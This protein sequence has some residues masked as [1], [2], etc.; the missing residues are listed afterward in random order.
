M[1]LP[2]RQVHMSYS[3]VWNMMY[4]KMKQHAKAGRLLTVLNT[5]SMSVDIIQKCAMEN[6]KTC[7]L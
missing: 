3:T 1:R 7:L 6:R 4:H 2:C 5:F